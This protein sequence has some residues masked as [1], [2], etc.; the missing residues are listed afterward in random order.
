MLGG[1]FGLIYRKEIN[2][3]EVFYSSSHTAHFN[4]NDGPNKLQL[5]TPYVISV[6]S[7]PP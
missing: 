3:H 7:G 5:T 4:W 1:T 6:T 2:L